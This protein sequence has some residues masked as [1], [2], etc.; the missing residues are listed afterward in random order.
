M[1]LCHDSIARSVDVVV[2]ARVPR[3]AVGDLLAARDEGRWEYQDSAW[4]A[5][6]DLEE[7]MATRPVI[8]ARVR[9]PNHCNS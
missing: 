7:F 6:N 2:T 1:A 4:I 5:T 3:E 8:D 9:P